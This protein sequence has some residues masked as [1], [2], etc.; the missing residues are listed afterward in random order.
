MISNGKSETSLPTP[1]ESDAG[2]YLLEVFRAA[3]AEVL[4]TERRQWARERALIEA[5]AAAA[6][7]DLRAA[8]AAVPAEMRE[9]IAA[10]LAELRNGIDGAAGPQGQPGPAGEPGP[11]GDPGLAGP[12][13]A[14]GL[15][16]PPG[17]IGAPG[18]RGDSGP[19]GEPGPAGERGLAGPAGERGAPGTVGAPGEPGAIGAMGP[20]GAPGER[21]PAGERG[22][23]GAP[24]ALSACKPFVEGAVHYEGDVIV[25]CGST[26]Q[27]HR[28]T[29]KAPPHVDWVLLAGAGRDAVPPVV[30]GTWRAEGAYRALNIVALNGGSFIARH[31]DPGAC[32][33]EGWQL[34]A[35]AGRAG[36][37]GP[38]GDRG[39]PGQRGERG[40]PGANAPAAPII[41]GWVVD[42]K[43]YA[44]TP[45]MSDASEGPRLD[46]RELFAQ[47]HSEAE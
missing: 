12:P 42:R 36:K 43:A 17:P 25:H 13:G 32:P 3:L 24:G 22:E 4:D 16:G 11:A 2:D 41:T 15:E 45:V 47:F 38:A 46:L 7:A 20:P 8:I 9:M 10:R 19:P 30:C 28:D 26:Y 27:A 1:I 37:S 23:K 21:G 35:S 34:I 6:M 39:E 18:V 14:A 44:A 29:A 31:D 40:M 33:G 5:Q